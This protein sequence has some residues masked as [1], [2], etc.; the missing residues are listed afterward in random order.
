MKRSLYL[1]TLL[2]PVLLT[3]S[4]SAAGYSFVNTPDQLKKI[5][6]EVDSKIT[7]GEVAL[8]DLSD[9]IKDEIGTKVV[10]VTATEDSLIVENGDG[11][12]DTFKISDLV[13][14]NFLK[15]GE[16]VKDELILTYN[17]DE[18]LRVK[19]AKTVTDV[20]NANGLITVT[21]ND[22]T[23][24]SWITSS[25]QLISADTNDSYIVLK[26]ADDTEYITDIKP[27]VDLLVSED[28]EKL[29]DLND[30]VSNLLASADAI[31]VDVDANKKDIGENN[32]SITALEDS[33]NAHIA[34]KIVKDVTGD[35]ATKTIKVVYSDDTESV[36]DVS[37]IEAV[38]TAGSYS[39]DEKKITVSVENGE[40]F[41]IDLTEMI[42]AINGGDATINERVDDIE[43]KIDETTLV[44]DDIKS[45]LALKRVKDVSADAYTKTIVITYTDDTTSS[46]SISSL[47]E[48]DNF[49]KS[50]DLYL[51]NKVISLT[52]KSGDTFKIDL[53]PLFEQRDSLLDLKVDKVNG[54]M[55]TSNDLTDSF[56]ELLLKRKVTGLK[57]NSASKDI[58][59]SYTDGTSSVIDLSKLLDVDDNVVVDG[60]ISI[61]GKSLALVL[62]D[63]TELFIDVTL[64]FDELN[65]KV[66]KVDG[67]GLS[68][69]DFTDEYKAIVLE[70]RIKSINVNSADKKLLINL[71]SGETKSIDVAALVQE[72]QV[73]KGELSDDDTSI[74]LT[75]KSGKTIT[76]SIIRLADKLKDKVDVEVGKVLS[77]NDFTDEEKKL[78]SDLSI[79]KNIVNVETID[80]SSTLK[81]DYSDG[82]SEHISLADWIEDNYITSGS[83][84][85][86]T[87]KIKLVSNNGKN[88]VEFSI[89]P[90]LTNDKFSIDNDKL[91]ITFADGTTSEVDLTYIVSK[92]DV[93]TGEF[94]SGSEEIRLTK[95]DGSTI[96]IDVSPIVN[97]IDTKVDMVDG[98]G[99]S[100]NDLTDEL[101]AK[102]NEG[103]VAD[104][105][106]SGDTLVIT[107]NDGTTKNIA[108]PDENNLIS[109]T[110][111][112]VN[113]RLVFNMKDGT[114][115]VTNLN[116][117]LEDMKDDIAAK[118]VADTSYD[119]TTNKITISYTDGST[120]DLDLGSL[121]ATGALETKVDKVDGMGL[122][123]N[124]YTDEEKAMVN[125]KKVL[126]V[127]RDGS[128]VT[129]HYSDGTEMVL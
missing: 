13:S 3:S 30:T 5:M 129:I 59:V 119:E 107:M 73:S 8:S 101:I 11:T 4:L 77:S 15:S 86:D 83:V 65:K 32:T 62:K 76:V 111:D 53:M 113:E 41:T 40:D 48:N 75:M 42:D 55:L 14:D 97:E 98:M 91:I 24:T 103:S 31:K 64:L 121:N 74:L 123:S 68:S 109:A 126:D 46:I 1:A 60:R 44:I 69:N 36:I 47:S 85:L 50:G 45:K 115:F 96:N 58:D 89:A 88:D 110:Y 117:G 122:S 118:K 125:T 128:E 78:L 10:K 95:E 120:T 51:S 116:L 17:N 23:N 79:Q 29:S 93:K 124:D 72:D 27:I 102:I 22:E 54:K 66:D 38:A 34:K 81:F 67:M 2:F 127:T 70:D 35:S 114:S 7:K 37:S 104:V 106:I 25:N 33:F 52:L 63:G 71:S 21:Y 87:S 49:V 99:L 108:L 28:R 18:E 80:E 19:F 57:L 61:S 6:D 39:V 92:N 100:S 82:T 12:Q 90:L 43:A 20:T 16:V 105:S 112:D 9:E 56:K 26:M 94:V 84:D